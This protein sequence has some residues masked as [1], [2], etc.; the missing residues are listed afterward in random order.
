MTK[1]ETDEPIN[2]GIST[3][4][5]A[6][7]A[8][9][10]YDHTIKL[11]QAHTGICYW[12]AQHPDSV[13]FDDKIILFDSSCIKFPNLL[14]SLINFFSASKCFMYYTRQTRYSLCW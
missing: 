14:F 7:L 13:S 5:K 8:T 11:W 10:G 1:S 9:G 3:E 12:T 6:I 4:N 2:G